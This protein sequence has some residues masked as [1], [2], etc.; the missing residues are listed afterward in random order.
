MRTPGA[1]DSSAQCLLNSWYKR[2]EPKLVQPKSFA[3]GFKA[4]GQEGIGASVYLT[5]WV[6]R[7]E[8]STTEGHHATVRIPPKLHTSRN[9][10]L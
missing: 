4:E 1:A 6:G 3:S 10:S 7:V 5:T 9:N 2:D 8:I